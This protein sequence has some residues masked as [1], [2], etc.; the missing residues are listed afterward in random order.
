[1]ADAEPATQSPVSL[2][3][4][5]ARIDV[6]DGDLLRRVAEETGGAYVPAGTAT[7]DLESIYREYIGPMTRG[8]LDPR[9]RT[10]RDEL[11]PVFVLLGFFFLAASVGVSSASR[12]MHGAA[13]A[14]VG[15]RLRQACS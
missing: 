4:V 12:R 13:T 2:E 14:G 11:Y 9:G 1:M 15:L 3:T 5:R 10:V 6:I 8:Q 7:L